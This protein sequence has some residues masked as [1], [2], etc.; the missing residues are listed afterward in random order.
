MFSAKRVGGKRAYDLARNE[1]ATAESVKLEPRSIHISR[2]ELLL[3][4]LTRPSFPESGAAELLPPPLHLPHFQLE[5]EVSGG[6]YIRALVDD[7]GVAVGSAA[8]MTE[9]VRTAHGD[10]ELSACLPV[11][12][13]EATASDIISGLQQ[14][15]RR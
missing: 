6:T 9:L 15:R 4:P 5:C 1:G 13:S 8:H 3:P 14:Q 2:L 12:L 7:I 11:S 10:F